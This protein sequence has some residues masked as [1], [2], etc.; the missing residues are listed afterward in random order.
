MIRELL[1]DSTLELIDKE[2]PDI[3]SQLGKIL[4]LSPDVISMQFSPDSN[5]PVASVCLT[6]TIHTL[7]G[8]RYALFEYYAHRLYYRE[9]AQP[10]NEMTAVF[11]ERYYA[12]DA[13]LRLYSAGEHVAN[14][15]IFMLEITDD[16]LKPYRKDR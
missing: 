5:I 10:P 2:L 4:A 9:R 12:D 7:A 14:V 8:A 1:D 13:A 16:E 6:D 11:F 3:T 15:V